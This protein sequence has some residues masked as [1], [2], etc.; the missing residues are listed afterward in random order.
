MWTIDRRC[1]RGKTERLPLPPFFTHAN[2]WLCRQPPEY[3]LLLMS[4]PLV[5]RTVTI[6]NAQGL[7]ARPADMVAR[8]ARRYQARIEIVK[9][10][11]RVDG[12][13]VLG[14]LTLGAYQGVEL[15][16][17][18][19]GEDAEDAVDALV[20]LIERKFEEE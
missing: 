3:T 4:E 9:G 17:C 13:S 16:I 7:H 8:L 10:N 18:A 6:V 15:T 1:I 19:C 12:K 2:I 20:D 14:L 11:E 5:T